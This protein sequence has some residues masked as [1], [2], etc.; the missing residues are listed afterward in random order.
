[1][2]EPPCLLMMPAATLGRSSMTD[3]T[4]KIDT[5]LTHAGSDPAANSGVIN[6]PVYRASTV[7][8]P[9]MQSL[10]DRQKDRF[11]PGN[12]SYGRHG[13]PT[14]FAFED[15][16][17]EAEGGARAVALPSG[18][19]A[20]YAAILAFVRA[21]DHVLIADHVY[22][23]TRSF[24]NG[25]LKRFGVATTF[26]DPMIGAGIAGLMRDNTK[27]L[28]MESPGSLT[29]EVQDVPALVAEARQ[30]GVVTII[31]NT[32]AAPLFFHPMA[33]GVDVSV[34]SATKYIVG[35]SDV[36]AGVAVCNAATFPGVRHSVA[37]LGYNIGPD[38]CY[39][40]LRGLRTAGVRMRQHE[41]QALALARWLDARPEVARVLHPAMPYHPGHEFW[42]RDF[43]GSSGLFGIVLEPASKTAVAAMLDGMKLFGMGYSWGG[44][45]SLI[46]PADPGHLRSATR[47]QDS[48]PV[49]RIHAGLEDLDDLVADLDAGF[50]RLRGAG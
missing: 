32:W 22:G 6:P 12:M 42:K 46:L 35:H 11:A 2:Q 24:A 8:H 43:T 21:G 26:Y 18:C 40:A 41:K 33:L 13:T 19:A 5:I 28:F 47:W 39:L 16:V 3:K 38:E 17:A 50:A 7:I 9:T 23:P 34:I 25:F 20:I 1:M 31:D 10:D 45:E 14:T 30:R 15:A 29:F 4:R 27:I 36:M 49:L 48:G 44:F 37:E